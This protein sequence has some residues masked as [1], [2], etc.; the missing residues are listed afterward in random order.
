MNP[1]FLRLTLSI[2]LALGPLGGTAALARTA[3]VA[4]SFSTAVPVSAQSLIQLQGS[5]A[6]GTSLTYATTTSPAHGALSQLNTSTGAVVYTP[7]TGYTGA[8]SFQYTVTSGG[9]TTSAAT[10]SITVTAAQTRV[11]ETFTNPDGTPRQ[12]KVSF[13]LT[14][15]SSSSSGLIPVK[16][17]VSCKLSPSGVCDVSLYP[18]RAVNPVQY[19]Q[20]WFDDSTTGNSQLIGI[21]DIPASTTTISLSGHRITDANLS[22]QFTF[23]SRA[24]IE[25]LSKAVASATTAALFPNLTAGRHILFNGSGFVDSL[26]VEG[27]SSVTVNANQTVNGDQTVSGGSPCRLPVG[28]N[29][30]QL[31]ADSSRPCGVRFGV[32]PAQN[33]SPPVLFRDEFTTTTGTANAARRPSL[34]NNVNA[35]WQAGSAAFEIQSNH[36]EPPSGFTD[37]AYQTIDVHASDFTYYATLTAYGTTTANKTMPGLIFRFEDANN[38]WLLQTDP[39]AGNTILYEKTSGVFNAR[40]TIP[41]AVAS[42][43]AA[44]VTVTAVGDKITA[45]LGGQT[46]VQYTSSAHQT[47]TLIGVRAGRDVGTPLGQPR[48]DD[49]TV[50]PAFARSGSS[51]LVSV[52]AGGSWE[53][54]DVAASGVAYDAQNARWVMLYSGFSGS[55]W[56]TGL[57]TSTNLLTW[58]KYGS[59]P[60]LSPVAGEGYIAAST[61]RPI[62]KNG[63]WYIVYQGAPGQTAGGP[64]QQWRLYA[65]SSPDL[66]TWTRLNGGAPI[67]PLG[68]GSAFDKDGQHDPDLRLRSDGYFEL[69]FSGRNSSNFT[70]GHSLSLNMTT[71]SAT[72]QLTIQ[73]AFGTGNDIGNITVLGDDPVKYSLFFTHL[74]GSSNRYINRSDTVDGGANF[75]YYDGVLYKG[76]AA[77]WE[78]AQVFDP[79]VLAIGNTLY[80]FYSAGTLSGGTEN[81]NAGI[82]LA[83]LPIP[84][85]ANVGLTDAT[86]GF[87]TIA[88]ASTIVLDF[89]GNRLVNAKVTLGG[90]RALD[91]LGVT[92]GAEFNLLVTQDGTGGHGLTLP[93]GWKVEGGAPTLTATAGAT[94]QLHGYCV[95]PSVCYVDVRKGFN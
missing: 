59:N 80:L 11:M 69:F 74:D 57:A 70:A 40:A 44:P 25:Q 8:D 26:V 92:D 19:Y 12:G 58:T 72:T 71:W 81:L 36:L 10:V 91:G 1:R 82:G 29:G 85:V 76:A 84:T 37:G 83:T 55:T 16:A 51:A 61:S 65:A 20:A 21:Y 7:T 62:Y 52:G 60:V 49:L 87:A 14:Q 2:L 35:S 22:A 23:A 94:D 6:D 88:D 5:D 9:D 47:A 30:M 38:F 50:F 15:V 43:T 86:L 95:S 54:N 33:N 34:A 42:G 64:Q 13:F 79:D 31:V 89:A 68:T 93:A 4:T 67:L 75:T 48:F 66:L 28:A 56:K 53:S 24:E 3:P 27:G 90:N 46:P 73:G 41:A 63:L 39:V 17:S 77:T 32:A 45:Q 78:S 18:S